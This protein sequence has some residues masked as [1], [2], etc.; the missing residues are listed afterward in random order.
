MDYKNFLLRAMLVLVFSSGAL[1]LFSYSVFLSRGID[2][3]VLAEETVN[4][5]FSESA[6]VGVSPDQ[7]KKTV[8]ARLEVPTLHINTV[9]AS[10][11]LDKR[12]MMQISDDPNEVAWFNLGPSPGQ[13]GSAV[14][15]GHY[16]WKDHTPAVFDSLYKIRIGDVIQVEDSNGLTTTIVVRKMERYFSGSVA[17]EVFQSKDGKSHLNLIT[18][19]GDWND[20]SKSY[21]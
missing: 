2:L 17:K 11:G 21:S 8:P 9:I 18:C 4:I 15:S 19:E 1:Y 3:G 12:G 13:A 14:I 16:G 20:D 10:S 5:K 6:V 7:Q